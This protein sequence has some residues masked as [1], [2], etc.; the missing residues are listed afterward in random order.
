MDWTVE[1]GVELSSTGYKPVFV[2]ILIIPVKIFSFSTTIPH[3]TLNKRYRYI[4][5]FR[6]HETF[7]NSKGKFKE[8]LPKVDN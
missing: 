7:R 4:D 1:M 3:P 8:N 5:K 6:N 2:A